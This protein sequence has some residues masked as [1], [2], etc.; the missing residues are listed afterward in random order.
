MIAD[1]CDSATR[2]RRAEDRAGRAGWPR[3][4]R[5]VLERRLAGQGAQA[6]EGNE[7]RA[8][9]AASRRQLPSAAGTGR[10]KA[11]R[12][13]E[14][15]GRRRARRQAEC[16]QVEVC[17]RG[18]LLAGPGRAGRPRSAAQRRAAASRN[19]GRNPPPLSRRGRSGRG[20]RSAPRGAWWRGG[21]GT[22]ARVASEAAEVA[23]GDRRARRDCERAGAPRPRAPPP[24]AAMFIVNL[25]SLLFREDLK[26]VV[27]LHLPAQC[28][29]CASGSCAYHSGERALPSTPTVYKRAPPAASPTAAAKDGPA[30][31]SSPGTARLTPQSLAS[32]WGGAGPALGTHFAPRLP[33]AGANGDA[34][35]L[36]GA[37]AAPGKLHAGLEVASLAIGLH[38]PCTRPGCAYCSR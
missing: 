17:V 11:R 25:S 20:G 28:S 13:A 35:Q 5:R 14:A 19:R 23:P 4:S 12:Q 33:A 18:R 30:A 10:R 3:A 8:W 37:L 38:R 29:K 24:P 36:N 9:R 26:D 1:R 7:V 21:E 6:A 34:A 16:I 31:R 32:T 2:Q 22:G 27:R 15:A